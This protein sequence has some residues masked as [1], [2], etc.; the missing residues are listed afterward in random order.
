ME[1]Q[2]HLPRVPPLS[3]TPELWSNQ[4]EPKTWKIWVSILVCLS[5]IH[6][7]LPEYPSCARQSKAWRIQQGPWQIGYPRG[8]L[9]CYAQIFP[10]V[11]EHSSSPPSSDGH[12]LR[13]TTSSKVL[14]PPCGGEGA[15]GGSHIQWLVH[16]LFPHQL[17]SSPQD[18]LRPRVWTLSNSAS[19]AA[20]ISDGVIPGG[21][22]HKPLHAN[23]HLRGN[24]E[25]KELAL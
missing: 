15:R 9:E 11:L 10:L 23:L 20:S 2:V 3:P 24:P 18:Q 7:R 12:W 4:L 13:A 1:S 21:R 17:Q 16:A 14:C 6:Q 25:L 22:F 19:P 5:F 8:I